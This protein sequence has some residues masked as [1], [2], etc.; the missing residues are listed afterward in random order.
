MADSTMYPAKSKLQTR[1]LLCIDSS[2]C[3]FRNLV[4]EERQ[5]EYSVL[6]ANDYKN[7]RKIELIQAEFPNSI[8]NVT[9]ND[10][11]V[12]FGC[13]GQLYQFFIPPGNYDITGIA[14]YISLAI[15]SKLYLQSTPSVRVAVSANAA[16]AKLDL[17][18]ESVPN[19][20]PLPAN[21]SFEFHKNRVIG[22]PE[23]S[24]LQDLIFDASG[25]FASLVSDTMVSLY[26][27]NAIY[28]QLPDLG[29]F[30]Q[31]VWVALDAQNQAVTGYV[32]D[33]LFARI[34]MPAAPTDIAFY[35][36]SAGIGLY[37]RTIPDNYVINISKRLRVRIV[38]V[39]GKP[40]D[41]NGIPHSM[42]LAIYTEN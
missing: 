29:S 31:N 26:S 25:R 39:T 3:V 38:D 22:F 10:N 17:M 20:V 15:S 13:M 12:V 11:S 1:Q 40:V 34:Q 23:G 7:V 32:N 9:P 4:E 6:L 14:N 16:T 41:F 8:F 2:R 18:F 5:S 24:V 30:G 42:L 19:T 21:F 33:S 27:P 37:S 36:D 35:T 28:L